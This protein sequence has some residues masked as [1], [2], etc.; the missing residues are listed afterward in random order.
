MESTPS[1]TSGPIDEG[2]YQERSVDPVEIEIQHFGVRHKVNKDANG[3]TTGPET[4]SFLPSKEEPVSGT[5]MCGPCA[6]VSSCR[7]LFCSVL[8]CGLYRV[9]RRLPCLVSSESSAPKAPVENQSRPPRAENGFY[10]DIRIGG[11]KVDTSVIEDDHVSFSTSKIEMDSPIY[12]SSLPEDDL[13]CGS[14]MEDVDKLITRK[15]MEVFSEFEINEL[16]KCTTDSMFL[17]RSREISQLISDIVEE[18]NMEEQEAECRLVREII[19]ISTRKSKKKPQV[20]PQELQRDSGNDTWNSK[21]NSQKSSFNSMSDGKLQI[22]MERSDDIE[23]RKLRNNSSQS[24]S[25]SLQETG[26]PIT[27]NAPLL[28]SSIRA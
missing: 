16:A 22:S 11:V 5:C 3:N 6:S 26:V 1:W 13:I 24:F 19:R 28:P 27:S 14:G 15:L 18:H 4:V 2:P 21:R 17:R 8:T 7:K 25:P 12:F 9:C 20:R 23:A 10:S